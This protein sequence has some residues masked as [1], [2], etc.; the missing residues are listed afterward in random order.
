[1]Q[2]FAQSF[3]PQDH[4]DLKDAI[5]IYF[6]DEFGLFA[7]FPLTSGAVSMKTFRL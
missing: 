6:A 3:K 1:M 7:L 5:L 2:S 4:V